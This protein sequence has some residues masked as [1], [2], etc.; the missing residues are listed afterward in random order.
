MNTSIKEVAVTTE[1]N[2]FYRWSCG[3]RAKG[4]WAY[5]S[6]TAKSG[7]TWHTAVCNFTI[8][9]EGM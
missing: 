7:A 6:E 8:T 2:T 1:T 5:F 9:I 4:S 3:C